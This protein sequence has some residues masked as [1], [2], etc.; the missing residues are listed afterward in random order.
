MIA[1]RFQFRKALHAK[2]KRGQLATRIER[3]VAR[4]EARR[5]A[6]PAVS[7]PEQL[8]VAGRV[9]DIRRAIDGN[10]VVIIAGE[11]GSG[12]T[13][14]IPKICL[15]MGRG[16]Y[17]MIGHTQPRRVA[18]RTV[19][20]RI[21]EELGVTPGNEVGYQVRFSD[22]T[23][24][25]SLVKVMTDG[26]LLAETQQDKFLEAY[27]TIIIDEAHERSLNIDFLLGY[28][29]RI[30]PKRPDLKVIVTSA[31]IDVERFSR[32]FNRAPVIEVS[33]RTYPVDVEYRPLNVTS[34]SEDS[35][36]A[37]TGGIIEVLREIES[38]DRKRSGPGDVLV[39]LAGEREIREVA[40]QIRKSDLKGIETLPLYS[41]LSVA[42]QNRVFQGHRSGRRVVLATNVAET[43]L[44]VPGIRYVIDPGVARISRYSVRSKVQQLPIEPVSK[45]SADQRKGR[46]G[47]VSEGTCF[48]L[49]TEEDFESRP[50]FTQPEIMR[51]NLAAVI[52]QMLALRLGDI[53][54]FPFVERPDQRQINDGFHLL[55][56]LQAVDDRKQITR[57]GRDL[58]R[59]PIDLR[60][61]RM[62]VE[63]GKNG[64]LSE[65]L[66]IVSVMALQDPRDRPHEHQQ[67]ADEKHRRHWDEQSDFLSLVNL[68]NF[69][70]ENRQALTQ[71]QLRKFC[72]DNFLSYL[73]MREWRE[74]HRQLHLICRDMKLRENTEPADYE[75]IHRSLLAGLLGNIGE[76]VDENEYLGAR[77][78]RHYIFPASSQFKRKPKWIVS[79]EL[80]ETSRLF[81][82]TVAQIEPDWVE[83]L[84]RHLVKRNY[85][86]PFFDAKQGQVFAY[87]EVMLYGISIVKK[88]RVDF[89]A[90]DPVRARQLFIQ[91]GLV[92]RQLKTNAGFYQHNR[93]L[94]EEV[95]A[96]ESKSR[97]RD[98]MVD[99]YALYRFYDARL[100]DDICSLMELDAWRRQAERKAPKCLYLTREDL[101][102]QDTSLSA[103]AYPEAIDVGG[104]KL[105]LDYHFDPQHEDDGVSVE[106]P[107]GLLRQVS[108]QKLE[109]LIPGLLEEK[110]LALIKSLPKSVR[111]HFVPA[112]DYA[113][114]VAESIEYDGRALTE[115]LAERLFRLT[116]TRVDPGDFKAD[117]LDRHLQ[118]NIRVIDDKGKTLARSR[119]LDSLVAE[120]G[121]QVDS[122]FRRRDPHDIEVE[123]QTDWSFG[124]LPAS[125][126]LSQAGYSLTGYPAIRDEG[127]SIAIEIVDN[128]M[129]AARMTRDGLVRLFMLKLKDQRKYVEKNFP[130]AKQFSIYF[131][132]REDRDSLVED[133]VEA[134]FRHTFVEDQPVPRT[135]AEFD[136]RLGEKQYLM[137]NANRLG[138]LMMRVMKQ[139]NR[140]ERALQ[141]Q[142]TDL[143]RHAIR[144]VRQQLSRLV[145]P[146]FLRDVPMAWLLEYPRYLD[147]IEYRLDKM[148][149]ALARDK[150]STAEIQRFEERV[151]GGGE[152][153]LD[154][155]D[156]TKYRWMLEEYRVSL[157]AQPLGTKIPVSGKRLERAWESFTAANER[158]RV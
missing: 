22:Q 89:G 74:N 71:K 38:I 136:A 94:I 42:E 108:R 51:T 61:G 68:W 82:R 117:G 144:D 133:L 49:Y 137:T 127:D 101:M 90:V 75:R 46:C 50:D 25:T 11:T 84:A 64:C 57:L 31:T 132:T 148:R 39:F 147:A 158:A 131:A 19:S 78:R 80:V 138:D 118:M 28:I 115:V 55:K 35:D 69:Y 72:R 130:Q 58:A 105:R 62:L 134:V 88:R 113:K 56:E 3:S 70:E 1:D 124:D 93:R 151:F 40:Q 66:T 29:K 152:V 30:L 37:I 149:G 17:G 23:T 111:K 102:R 7:Y 157:F 9:D 123:G 112:P 45:A 87:E 48:R 52:L 128:E 6:L 65:V 95:E 18:A 156:L 83:P 34:K 155:A 36:E 107:V 146:R 119:D 126:E 91:H 143:N 26:I 129:A 125:V 32:H 53:S 106:V 116:G 104:S 139:L 54:K 63:A 44:T 150:E 41:R 77:N 122:E 98:I 73:R 47:R 154:Q 43:S 140:I 141:D 14:Q 110:S 86:E 15:D 100:P 103:E 21:A 59:I 135:A 97:K 4:A 24:D 20:H 10:Q 85:H 16:V 81:A 96:L 145:P 120:F 5:A 109:W 92:E 142:E 67:A 60:L 76:K 27:D 79:A 8:P 121:E 33:G 2:N 99:G 12:K 13:T 114:R 153:S